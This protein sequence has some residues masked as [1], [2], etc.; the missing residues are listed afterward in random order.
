MSGS[1]QGGHI[2]LHLGEAIDFNHSENGV[3]GQSEWQKDHELCGHEHLSVN[4]GIA[5]S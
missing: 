4:S 2:Y 3:R 5:I 1:S